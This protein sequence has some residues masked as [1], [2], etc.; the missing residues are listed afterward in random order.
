MGCRHELKETMWWTIRRRQEVAPLQAPAN[1]EGPSDLSGQGV[2][3]DS[4][5]ERDGLS[6]SA[7]T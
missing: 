7:R 5:R 2:D 3:L 4:G 6:S 1:A